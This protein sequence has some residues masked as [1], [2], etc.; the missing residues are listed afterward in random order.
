MRSID[1]IELLEQLGRGGMGVVY[2]GRHPHLGLVAVK[3]MLGLETEDRLRFQREAQAT[4]RIRSPHVVPVHQVGESEGRPYLVM[5]LVEGESLAERVR[6]EG[7]L[8]ETTAARI[9]AQLASALAAAHGE[10]VL[11]RDLKPAN[12]LL[13]E[14]GDALLGDFGLALLVD[15]GRLTATGEL[16]GSP[17]YMAPE[18]ALGD[19]ERLGPRTDVYALGA[20]LYEMLTGEVPFQ[21]KAL[22]ALLEAVVHTTLPPLAERRPGLS[23]ELERICLRCLEKE[24]EARFES[25]L[26]VQ[27]ALEQVLA[28]TDPSLRAV[29]RRR[30]R[31]GI[32]AGALVVLGAGAALGI[33]LGVGKGPPTPSTT[34]PTPP[35]P[36]PTTQASASA[37]PSLSAPALR[38]LVL[39]PGPLHGVDT[40]VRGFGWYK[41][42]NYGC[43]PYMQVGTRAWGNATQHGYFRGYVRFDLRRLPAGAEVESATLEL[44]SPEGESMRG[45]LELRVWYT[46]ARR[47]DW[48]EGSSSHDY[49]VDGLCWQGDLPG[50]RGHWGQDSGRPDLD[51]PG[52]RSDA[53]PL[54]R[55]LVTGR[56]LLVVSLD[57]TEAVRAWS[58]GAA[59]QGFCL[60]GVEQGTEVS[61]RISLCTSDWRVPSQRPRLVIRY[62]GEA[63]LDSTEAAD[64]QAAERE[65]RALMDEVRARLALGGPSTGVELELA[66][67]AIRVAPHWWETYLARAMVLE[68][69]DSANWYGAANAL[70][71]LRGAVLQAPQDVVEEVLRPRVLK[72]LERVHLVHGKPK[73]KEQLFYF[74]NVLDGPGFETLRELAGWTD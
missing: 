49:Y 30:A 38:T 41:N 4:A 16:L 13:N 1:G 42:D 45:D 52:Y 25:A 26:A 44:T 59:N 19:R 28:R 33:V 36:S 43:D 54:A 69:L 62:R 5:R 2:R 73:L 47:G 12:V 64:E 10:G 34:T 65:A 66:S 6:R 29:G 31:V 40:F 32:V 3:V 17:N 21:G 24:P 55:A 71:D 57:V 8:P 15:R 70:R 63:P 9:A 51:Q 61:S 68:R 60:T 14:A 18:Q 58:G 22:S 56:E 7:P 11:H 37:P 67:Q 27:S 50:G 35:S 23:P 72:N 53:Q 74:R 39:Q 46:D 48:I 20:T